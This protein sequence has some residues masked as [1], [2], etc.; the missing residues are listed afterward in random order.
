VRKGVGA[1]LSASGAT[2]I[3]G[4]FNFTRS[5]VNCTNG[6]ELRAELM[7]GVASPRWHWRHCRNQDR[8]LPEVLGG[9]GKV[10]FISRPIR[11]A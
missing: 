4:S 3:A 1:D 6:W 2:R 10:E 9:G 11:T 7:R 8:E 5:F